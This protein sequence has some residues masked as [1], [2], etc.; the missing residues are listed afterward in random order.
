MTTSIDRDEISVG[1][2]RSVSGCEVFVMILRVYVDDSA[3]GKREKTIVAGAFVGTTKQW[4]GLK[5]QW[6]RRLKRDGLA[7]FRSTEYYSLRGEFARYRDSV[8]Y[9]K[10]TGSEAATALRADLDAIIK[11]SE[12]MGM[13]VAIPL[14]MYHLI[15][16]TEF[17]AK[18]L[19]SP[20]PFVSALQSLIQQCA[21][22]SR[23]ELHSASL[24]FICDDGP[25]SGQVAQTYSDF[26][27]LRTDIAPLLGALVH[28]N[29]KRF[30]QL[31]AADLMA[32]LARENYEKWLD[33]PGEND[34]S[35]LEGS[36]H[37]ID[38]WTESTMR[39]VLSAERRKLWRRA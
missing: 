18:E 37:R 29:D 13:G 16:E 19:F 32:H 14:K 4:S 34:L 38:I 22:T 35:R 31:Q 23:L 1:E 8:R 36:V 9:P 2:S 15:R 39:D 30:P 17:G 7:Y 25:S 6:Q 33:H 3:D 27:A 24:A 10:P 21:E 5:Q 11:K 28:Q 26:K 12:V 20:D